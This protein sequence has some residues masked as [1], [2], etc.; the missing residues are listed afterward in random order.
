VIE[1]G[2]L[3]LGWL[4]PAS[5]RRSPLS[6]ADAPERNDR[7]FLGPLTR[8]SSRLLTVELLTQL[9]SFVV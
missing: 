7:L 6:V 8:P 3:F 2:R 5:S 9:N 1:S 4:A